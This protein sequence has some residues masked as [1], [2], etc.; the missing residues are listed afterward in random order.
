[1][2][3]SQNRLGSSC[4]SQLLR[5]LTAAQKKTWFTWPMHGLT[6]GHF[7][8]MMF[9]DAIDISKALTEMKN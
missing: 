2:T 9:A 3:P 7:F 6:T 4:V 5:W 8:D 1:M